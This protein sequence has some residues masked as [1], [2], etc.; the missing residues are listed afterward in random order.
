MRSKR[1]AAYGAC[2]S[3]LAACALLTYDAVHP[4]FPKPEAVL[5]WPSP[6]PSSKPLLRASVQ[7]WPPD[8]SS[9]AVPFYQLF[10][11]P[12]DDYDDDDSGPPGRDAPTGSTSDR[13]R[14]VD[15]P[16]P[17]DKPPAVSKETTGQAGLLPADQA[18]K[19]EDR[20]ERV[21][22]ARVR[23]RYRYYHHYRHRHHHRN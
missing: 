4:F 8:P 11:S 18:A 15:A 7:K 2:A 19:T 23:G 16:K 5:T 9:A 17:A 22:D 6:A 10:L 20:D 1:T 21:P 12:N 13:A 3:V 14:A